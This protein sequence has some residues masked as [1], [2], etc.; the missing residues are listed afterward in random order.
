MVFHYNKGAVRAVSTVEQAATPLVRPDTYRPPT[1]DSEMGWVVLVRVEDSTIVIPGAEVANTLTRRTATLDKNGQP[2]RR[3][4]SE[5]SASDAYK[6][7]QAAHQP[8]LEEE[9]IAGRPIS[10]FLDPSDPTDSVRWGKYRAEQRILRSLLLAERAEA[11]CDLCGNRLPARVLV[12]AHIKPRRDC[13]EA[14]RKDFANVAM[15]LCALGCDALFEWGY[16]KVDPQG[17]IRRGTRT[18]NAYLADRVATLDGRRCRKHSKVTAA[19]FEAR[20]L[21]AG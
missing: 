20:A 8:V 13:T 10:E 15:L 19:Y 21:N 4:L 16:I 7:L 1:D 9:T 3:Y 12:A 14:E 11:P 5:L 17:V 6:L 2:N 18:R